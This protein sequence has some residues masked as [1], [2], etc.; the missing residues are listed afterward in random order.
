MT[1]VS[2]SDLAAYIQDV[3]EVNSA[4][5]IVGRQYVI[6]NAIR[7]YVDTIGGRGVL[8]EANWTKRDIC[9]PRV[10]RVMLMAKEDIK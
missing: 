2:T 5:T 8:Y 7:R 1:R 9:Y 4:D 10:V 6:E 3:L